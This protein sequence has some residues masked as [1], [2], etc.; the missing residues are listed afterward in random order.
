[1]NMNM[2][3]S[4]PQSE[5][6]TISQF[7]T[8]YTHLA[9]EQKLD[10][11][12]GRD[13]EIRR[14]MQIITRRTKNN[15]IL[16]GDP[17]VGKTALVEGLAQ[18][19]VSGDVPEI[20]KQKEIIGLDLAALLAGASYRGEFEKRLKSLLRE[21]EKAE[22]KYILF[23]DEIHTLVGAG[24]SE[25][26]IDA[27]N[28]LKPA[29]A[30]GLLRAIGATT[31]KEYRRFFEND[32]ALSR[33]FQP[34]YVNEPSFEDTLAILRG[35][36]HKYELHHGIKIT[37]AALIMAIELS[38][39]YLPERFLPD[40]AI[41]L[42][43]EASSTLKIEIDSSPYSLDELKRSIIQDEIEL[44]ALKREGGKANKIKI[45][46]KKKK[47]ET[48]K[49][50]LKEL[51]NKYQHQKQILVE[52][53]KL[54]QKLDSLQGE[55]SKAE[56]EALLEKAAEIKFGK[57]PEVKKELESYEKQW[58][59]IAN[60][61]RLIRDKVTEDE[62]ARVVA[63]WTQIPVERML[64]SEKERLLSLEDE[65]HQRVVNQKE[66][67]TQVAKAI[68]RSRSGFGRA[69]VPIGV[70]LFVGPTGVGKTETAKAL[71]ASLFNSESSLVRIDMSEYSQPHS[72]SR[73]IGAP[74][75]YVGFEE[76]GQLTEKV[77]RQPYSVI[78]FD[79]IE[80]AHP[81]LFNVFLQIFDEGKLTDGQGRTVSFNNTVIIL[82]SNIGSSEIAAKGKIDQALKKIVLD[83]VRKLLAPEILNRISAVVIFENL[84][85]EMLRQIVIIQLKQL[86]KKLL[87]K[88][89]KLSYDDKVVDYL[90]KHG[91]D[92][93][94]G[95]RPLKRLIDEAVIDEISYLFIDD[96]IKE[97]D[98]LQATVAND[99]VR[100]NKVNH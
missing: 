58:G 35:I 33:R 61:D 54:R 3:Y 100:I 88:N 87:Q 73:L 93:I 32:Q 95:A 65:L 4:P 52:L 84:K 77:R 42:L 82:T 91:Y 74:P 83:K 44:T 92:P 78:L 66:A 80:K 26:A 64:K 31:V 23:I 98:S 12:I 17:G 11:V 34:I 22:G 41:D 94:Y 2:R 75:G 68:R 15:P 89:I 53:N 29:L 59:Q 19:I 51:Q 24:S 7:T 49:Q 46:D 25:G 1:M 43:D 30:R 99:K 16:L 39:R 67:I 76:G 79:E 6:S 72:L 45:D 40:K 70:F 55:L 81:Q 13:N 57:I 56:Q 38:S 62:I 10:P 21:I 86:Q 37:D 63:K 50:K 9:K 96:Q 28:M 85:T 48:K 5:K 97:G 60:E 8:N 71:A 27:A 90:R 18:R 20:L 69:N 14:L 36:K 47:I